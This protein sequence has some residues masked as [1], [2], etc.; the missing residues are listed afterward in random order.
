MLNENL[1]AICV[2]V[3]ALGLTYFGLDDGDL[4]KAVVGAY[5]GYLIGKRKPNDYQ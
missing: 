1:V 5:L 4:I 3:L 2:T